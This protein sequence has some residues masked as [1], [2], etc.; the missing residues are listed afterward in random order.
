MLSR[1]L[2]LRALVAV[3][4]AVL[5]GAGV[6]GADNTGSFSDPVGDAGAGIDI[7]G[8]Q[9]TDLPDGTLLFEVTV[10]GRFDWDEDGP[11]VALDLDQNP[12]IGSAFYRTEVEMAF[13]GHGNAREGE[14]VLLRARG[15]DFMSVP[16]PEASG[17]VTRFAKEVEAM[18][19]DADIV[20][21]DESLD[22]LLAVPRSTWAA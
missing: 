13:Q 19:A 2:L 9:V 7:T 20:E 15:W 3:V 18:P 8:L 22:E 17:R 6:A 11:L 16:P 12:D 5:V 1:Q 4:A 21:L 14:P 10:A